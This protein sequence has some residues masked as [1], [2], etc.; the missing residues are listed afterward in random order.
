MFAVGGRFGRRT[1]NPKGMRTHAVKQE[2][3][4]RIRACEP[5]HL[6]YRAHHDRVIHRGRRGED[7]A[8]SLKPTFPWTKQRLFAGLPSRCGNA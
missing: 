7:V 3:R 2:R 4:L 8:V 1:L 6:S 5:P